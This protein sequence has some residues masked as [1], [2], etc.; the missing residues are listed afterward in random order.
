MYRKFI[1][2]NIP[3]V[4]IIFFVLIFSIIQI[5]KPDFLYDKDGSIRKFGIGRRKKTILPIWFLTIILSF[6]CY[7][8]ILYY[9]ALPKFN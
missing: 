1:R 8:G 3:S 5:L 7:C 4:S 9:L 2:R 6:L